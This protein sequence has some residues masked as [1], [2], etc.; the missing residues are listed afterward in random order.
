MSLNCMTGLPDFVRMTIL[1][2]TK[3][4]LSYSL[5][6]H[7]EREDIIQDLILFYLENF[8]S[9]VANEA[10]VVVSIK[11]AAKN[12]LR[13][14]SF[15]RQRIVHWDNAGEDNP[16][17]EPEDERSNE[18]LRDWENK[19]EISK[20]VAECKERVEREILLLLLNGASINKIA[21]SHN[22]SKN[23]IRDILHKIRKKYI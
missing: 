22:I 7:Q 6:Q 4:L 23:T 12:M 17:N 20:I 10:Y 5:F 15:Y 11:N 3:K 16:I 19:E 2:E 18:N 8:G 1:R 21:H 9:I 13:K 14:R